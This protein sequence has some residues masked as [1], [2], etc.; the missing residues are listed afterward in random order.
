MVTR[1]LP[2]L[3]G[4]T[5]IGIPAPTD[6]PPVQGDVL[7]IRWP[8]HVAPG[9]LLRHA[10]AA[11]P[12]PRTGITVAGSHALVPTVPGRAWWHPT[13][14][15]TTAGTL[16]VG[17]DGGVILGHHHHGD[18]L[19]GPGAYAVRVQRHYSPGTTAPV[20]TSD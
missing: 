10:Q 20:P 19:I 17:P 11:H 7:V 9:L 4:L 8:D 14:G 18:R 15:G 1:T 13:W 5:G 12:I 16:L 2:D 6:P 3:V